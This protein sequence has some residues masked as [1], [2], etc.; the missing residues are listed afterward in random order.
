MR[1]E[2][3]RKSA[4]LAQQILD[5]LG[6]ERSERVLEAH[7]HVGRFVRLLAAEIEHV[8]D[9]RAASPAGAVS[10]RGHACTAG[11]EVQ[12]VGQ[13]AAPV[14]CC[15]AYLAWRIARDPDGR[16]ALRWSRRGWRSRRPTGRTL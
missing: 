13:P 15:P 10:Q 7:P 1:Y 8:G 6:R 2:L 3:L 16:P 5:I 9:R 4:H 14:L 12:A 11:G